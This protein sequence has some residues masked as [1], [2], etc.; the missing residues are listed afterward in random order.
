MK[1]LFL[2]LAVLTFNFS[3]PQTVVPIADLKMND[4]NGVPL[5]TGQ[6]FTVTGIV[7]SANQFGTNGPG[8]IQ[9]ATAGLSIFGSGFAGQV[10]IGDSVTVTSTLT[11][12]NGLTQFDFRRA[13]SVLVKHSSNHYFDTT[14]VTISDIASQQWNGF[15]EFESRLIRINNVTIQATGNFASATNYNITDA[16]G[17]LSA[18][19]RID[20]DVTSIIGQPIPQTS[21]DLVGILGQFKTS[22]PYNTGYQLLPRFLSDIIYDNSPLILNPVIASNITPEGFTVYFNTARNGNSQVK[23]GLTPSLELDSVVINNDTTVHIVP[24]SGLQEGTLYYFRAYSTNSAGTSFSSLQTVTTA[25]ANPQTGTINVYFNFSVDTT[26]AMTGNAA[27]GNVNFAQKLIERI[28]AATYSIDMALYSFSDLPDVANAIIAAK[29]RG[30]KVRVVYENRT[31]QNSMQAL[32]DAGIPVIKRTS[33]L[34]GIMHN[35]FFVFDARDTIAVNDWLWTGSWNV[36]L[37]ES[38][39]ENNVVE[40]NDPTITQAYKIEF[41]EMWGSTGDS[42]NPSNAKF[43]FQKSDNTPHIFNIGGREVKVYF[44]P[45]D[46]VMGKIVNTINTANKDIYFALYAFTRS[47]IATAMNNRFNAGVTDIRGLIDQVSTS[48]SQY[49]YLNT[50][51]EMFGNQGATMHHKYGLVDATQTY[52]NPY[53]ITGSA[54]WSNSASNDNDENILIIDDIFIANQY[55]QEFKRRYNEDGGTNT[56][57]IPII[58]SNDDKSFEID[59]FKLYQNYPNPFNPTTTIRFEVAKAQNL[60]LVV[61]DLLGREVKVLFDQFAPVGLVTVDFKADDL[62]SGLYIYRLIGENVNFSRKMMLLK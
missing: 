58:I 51:A 28:N 45:S 21:V 23:Y 18:G 48:G 60:K 16:T 19:L 46:G 39:W 61:Y 14:I 36:T 3:F 42:P 20:N 53:V 37:T 56:F 5:D 10:Q 30:V 29:N 13:G 43:G 41:E 26:V 1:K 54:N 47:D 50:F 15:E 4:P 12:F 24:V 31:T 49:S 6:V 40:I 35:K 57:I 27:K 44:S 33:G 25:S 34:N 8:S 55:M 59:D 9:D 62:S 52:S 32:I 22:A 2:F 7:T 11:H 17:T 38:N